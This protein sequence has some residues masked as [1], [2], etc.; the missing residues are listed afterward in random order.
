MTGA[1][2]VLRNQ[3]RG[4]TGALIVAGVT[5][6][7][8]ETWWI[9]RELRASHLLVSSVV[10]LGVVLVLT[11]SIGFRVEEESEGP[12]YDPVRLGTDFAELALQ[13]VVAAF[14]VLFAYGVVTLS[15]PAHV[16]A[17]VGLLQIV[18]LGFGAALSNRLL[19]KSEEEEAESPGELRLGENAAVFGIGAVFFALPVSASVEI[20]VLA[21]TAG[22]NRL[23]GITAMSL[24]TAYLILYELE[25]R[26]QSA[27]RIGRERAALVHAGQVCLV[28]AVALAVSTLLLWGYG[29]LTFSPA[30]DVQKVVV[31]SF[32]TTVGGA[33]ARVII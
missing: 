21:S 28:Y 12:E 24:T 22:W 29:Y 8:A 14:A 18:P 4:V 9:A 5:V 23:A 20:D 11:R 1:G 10:G 33:A 16:V 19:R 30:V 3:G 31:L 26:G 15:T 6:L 7:T 25:F 17:R 2:R 13:S 27:R 32:P